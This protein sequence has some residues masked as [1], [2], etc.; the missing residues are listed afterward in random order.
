MYGDI[1]HARDN[2]GEWSR[3][4]SIS[5]HVSYSNAEIPQFLGS[6]ADSFPRVAPVLSVLSI[7]I[8]NIHRGDSGVRMISA[9][10]ARFCLEILDK[11]QDR[12]PVVAS[13]YP[14][15]E[16]LIKRHLKGVQKQDEPKEPERMATRSSIQNG[17]SQLDSENDLVSAEPTEDLFGQLLQD[18]MS[19]TF[20]FSFPFGNLFE[21]IFLSSPSQP[22][23]FHED[24]VPSLHWDIL[25][26]QTRTTTSMHTY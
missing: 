1:S 4:C 9:H 14:I 7:H 8:A 19:T 3:I 17:S 23:S 5:E 6:W 10:R 18:N 20:P 11:L 26:R 21:E 16:F 22:T 25:R 12:F 24:D 2:Y 13:F 15:Y